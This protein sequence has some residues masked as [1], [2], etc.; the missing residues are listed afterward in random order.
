MISLT[1]YKITNQI[2]QSIN[3]LV[4]RGIRKQDNLP[5]IIKVLR[6][7]Y[8]TPIQ[9]TRYKQEYQ[10]THD[11]AIKG[12]VKAYSLA[13]HQNTLVIIFEDFG[14]ESLK[15][16]MARE[17]ITLREFLTIAIT[18]VTALGNIHAANIIHKDINPSNIVYNRETQQLKIIDFGI[19]TRLVKEKPTLKNPDILEGTL[20]YISPEQTGRMNRSLDYR[21]DFYSLGV[22]F[23][24]LLTGR[25]PFDTKDSLELIYC[26]LAK[27]AIPPHKLIT[28]NNELSLP[29]VVSQIVMKLMA[30]AA[31]DGYQTAWGIKADLT[32]CLQQ[33][34][35]T[36]MIVDFAIATCDIAN[37]FQIPEKLY[38]RTKEIA[39]LL[40]AFKRISDST[41]TPS[42]SS[43]SN[44]S[45]LSLQSSTE[46]QSRTELLLVTG[47]SG[48]GK[49]ALVKEIYQPI[50][51]KKGYY[52]SGKFDQYQ[53][54]IPYYAVIQAFK[55]LIEQ[56]LTESP[57]QLKKWQC[58][59]QAVLGINAQVIIDIIPEL[60]LIIGKQP[61]I[62]ELQSTEAQNRFNLVL[63]NF[64][65][66][67]TKPEHPLV[68]FLDDLQWA[69]LASLKLMKLLINN[70]DV[71]SLLL[72][73]A[74]RDNEIDTAHPLMLT[75]ED[76]NQSK[77]ITNEIKLNP[78]DLADIN[79]FVAD[80]LHS[81]VPETTS[82][83]ELLQ[84]K[85]NGNPF[86]LREFLKS[87]YD[88]NLL[89][90]DLQS[91]SWHWNLAQIK[92]QQITDNVVDLMAQKIKNLPSSTQEV[93]KLSSCIG[94]QFELQTLTIIAEIDP[95][96]VALSLHHAIAK[97]LILPLSDF[98]K[99]VE[100]DAIGKK[101]AS[102]IKQVKYKF[103][104]DRIQQAAYS[105]IPE[106]N[107]S[108]KHLQIGRLLLKYSSELEQ[109][110]NI[111]N[112]VNQFNNSLEL[113]NTELERDRIAK[114]NCIAAQKAKAS[115]AYQSAF[116][117]LNISRQLLPPDSWLNDYERT[118]EVYIEIADIAYLNSNYEQMQV[119][120]NTILEQAKVTL[121]KVCAYEIR[122]KAN[123]AQNKL[124]AGIE[125]SLLIL[126][127]L[128]FDFPQSPH[129]FQI[130][131][132]F[133]K[134]KI[135]L[136]K[137]P[138][139]ELANLPKM[140]DP[141]IKAAIRIIHIVGISVF[142]SNSQL[143][144]LMSLKRID[145]SL[146]YGNIEESA[147]AYIAY[148]RLITS[149]SNDISTAY[150]LGEVALNV[151]N[152][153]ESQKH[154][155]C[156][157]FLVNFF[158]FPYKKHL[159]ETLGNFII[160]Y[161][162]N[163]EVGD[164][165]YAASSLVC[166]IIYAYNS[167]QE[168][169]EVE[170][171]AKSFI[172]IL[173][174]IKQ[175]NLIDVAKIYHQTLINLMSDSFDIRKLQGNVYDEVQMLTLHQQS[176]NRY[177]IFNLYFQKAIVCY[178]F[179]SNQE[180]ATHII[181]AQQNFNDTM[182]PVFTSSLNFY[183]SLISLAQYNSVSN[184]EQTKIE[185]KVRANQKKMKQWAHHAPMNYQHKYYLV[186]AE[187][188]RVLGNATQAA[189]LYVRSINLAH[190]NEYL[191]EE[192]LA[193][194][195]AANFYLSKGHNLV[196]CTYMRQARYCYLKWGAK[197]KVKHLDDDHPKL[198]PTVVNNPTQ[199]NA[200]TVSSSTNQEV[201]DLNTLI[202]TS[203]ALA[204]I[205]DFAQLLETLIKFVL[206]NAGAAKG[207]LILLQADNLIIQG[208]GTADKITTLQALPV[209]NCPDI[210]QT[211]INYVYRTQE[212]LVLNNASNE[213]LF[214]NDKYISSQQIKSVLCL[215]ILNQGKLIGILYLENN[216]AENAFTAERL[217]ILKLI[218][219]QVA[220]SI[221]N[222][223]LRQQEQERV[224]EYQVGGC[225]TINAPTYVIRK[226]DSDLYQ[227]LKQGHCCYILNSRHMGK[228]SL[229]V[230]IM[231]KLQTE[232]VICVALDLTII[233]SQKTTIEQWYAGVIYRLVNSLKLSDKFD[234]RSWWHSLDLLSPVQKFSEFI[235]QILLKEIRGKIVIFID[236][237]D[238]T[239]SLNFKMDDFFAVIRAC[240]NNRNDYPEYQRLNFVLLGVATSTS[241]I[242]DQHCT[243]FNIGSAIA[244]QG[245]QLHEVKPLIQGLASK[246]QNP[247]ILIKQVL[248]WTGGQPFLTQK[249]CNLMAN[250]QIPLTEGRETEWV[251][252]LVE[253]K[254]VDN[255][256]SKDDPQ[257][258]KTIRDRLLN[259]SNP[260]KILQLYQ[261]ILNHQEIIVDD[262]KEH[263]ELLLS[264]LVKQEG[265]KF[266][267]YNP[268][269]QSVFNRAWC[270]RVLNTVSS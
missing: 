147:I 131:L 74:Y 12:V 130:I 186:E 66:V 201:L 36:G 92:A 219:A 120:T 197:A 127:L 6:Q 38:G 174:K 204:Q 148:A 31:E 263:K 111:F 53:K 42:S 232:G 45:N 16:L 192:A 153:F 261:Q 227:N 257:H 49:S 103:V 213:G 239:L 63:Q 224:F 135:N 75:L 78:I 222:I 91:L 255:W 25:L 160:T 245:F 178:L 270:T 143:Y 126:K 149:F 211:I 190:K 98:Y 264:G 24:E 237:I 35:T 231:N 253:I 241:L 5:V 100:L 47:Y 167:G 14:G 150:Q 84:V 73:G 52:I 7:D 194:E 179:Q 233:G 29:P 164:L 166:Y 28:A 90:F 61:A 50:T 1:G 86:F 34:E 159:R 208:S 58:K 246:Y 121:D 193:N 243:P 23:Y 262:S 254:I 247:Q 163:L 267:V 48:I 182:G 106:I 244:L 203:Q 260:I 195:L 55:K 129:K 215:S 250:V 128:G 89:K 198:L 59:L 152:Q 46:T 199:P 189:D 119:F 99:S 77:T 37:Q 218:S 110:E 107:K 220:I 229:R 44:L 252:N 256:E 83:A 184:Q 101:S 22:T 27:Q 113:I 109:E 265:N 242:Q 79:Q 185:Q 20:A 146:R 145:F 207:Y 33:L 170:S 57:P 137:V 154:K 32:E 142:M 181:Q 87:L 93:L 85:T 258:F 165:M 80:T 125:L 71:N 180:A 228:S 136:L 175:Q 177:A 123:F 81:S 30:K 102:I 210:S 188:S 140:S 70:P 162:N 176:N 112:I 132:S 209:D 26:H 116:N 161:G 196:G 15:I 238:S 240:Y 76:I 230:R 39:T 82:L 64:I 212:N 248:A 96:T 157:Y 206:E 235:Q 133:F 51:A 56:L 234:F 269:Y 173:N 139:S 97:G 221:E 236:E 60:E 214:I 266:Q 95:Q 217:E 68:L 158:I 151:I 114:L 223:L 3:S 115:A 88:D 168:I 138:V 2:H 40:T 226:A 105:L 104:H 108:A 19:S 118:L 187:T 117:Y 67:F 155:P 191:Q 268:I 122:I 205:T 134:T 156:L 9:L 202:K 200:I 54:D 171:K 8:P 21:S 216:L 259:S 72:I 62:P 169:I 65:Q 43:S 249:I 13:N 4:Y 94:N 251:D 144:L 141:T 41:S 183:D 172:S 124:E 17:R 11:L 10:I 69:D 18:I 225:L